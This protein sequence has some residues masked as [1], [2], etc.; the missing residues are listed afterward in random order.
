VKSPLKLVVH[1]LNWVA[2]KIALVV[3]PVVL[4]VFYVT[5]IAVASIVARIVGAD[6]LHRKARG[7]QTF[8]FDKADE[9][10]TKERYLAQ[11]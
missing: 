8:W 5:V 1:A 6:M 10:R 11:F 2:E 4:T 9:A 7:N 3:T